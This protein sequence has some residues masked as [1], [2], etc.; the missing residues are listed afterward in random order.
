MTKCIKLVPKFDEKE[1]DVFF[2][3]FEDMASFMKW[4]LEQW[5]WLIKP[6]F[7]GKAATVVGSLVGELDYKVIKKAVLDAYSVTSEGYRQQFRNYTKIFNKT[8]TEMAAE[9]L[10]IVQKV[11]EI[12][13]SK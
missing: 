4:P 13:G 2:K 6:K 11:V 12:R 7:I 10:K 1:V 8:W 9:K 3:N 5:V